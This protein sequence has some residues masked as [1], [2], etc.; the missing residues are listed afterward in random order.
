MLGAPALPTDRRKPLFV[1][2]ATLVL[3]LLLPLLA[4]SL[5][6]LWLTDL[7]LPRVSPKAA[8]WLGLTTSSQTV[9]T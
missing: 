3:A 1:A 5:L 7:L 6:L 2:V 8:A 4:A 9:T